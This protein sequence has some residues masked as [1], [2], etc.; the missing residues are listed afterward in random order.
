MKNVEDLIPL[1]EYVRQT[2]VNLH[3]LINSYNLPYKINI[4]FDLDNENWEKVSQ[5]H[6]R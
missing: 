6:A 2:Y 4:D 5:V 1:A 3:S